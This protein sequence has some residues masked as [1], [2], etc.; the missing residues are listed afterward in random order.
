MLRSE[1]VKEDSN[2]LE[3]TLLPNPDAKDE[4][5]NQGALN[6]IVLERGHRPRHFSDWRRGMTG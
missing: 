6:W 4:N 1:I 2:L 5:E 3:L